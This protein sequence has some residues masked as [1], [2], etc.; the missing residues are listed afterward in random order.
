M[1]SASAGALSHL[2]L[3]F[4]TTLKQ[5]LVP[6]HSILVVLFLTL[7]GLAWGEHDRARRFALAGAAIAARL[8]LAIG[9]FGWFHRYEVYVVLFSTLVVLYVL[10]ERQR[11]LLGWYVLGLLACAGPYIEAWRTTIEGT[12]DTY[13]LQYQ[14]HRFADRFY[15]GNVA[16]NDLGLVSYGRHPDQ[17]V[18]DLIGLGSVEAASEK[19][20][21][22]AWRDGITREH[23]IGAVMIFRSW[24]PDVPPDWTRVGAICLIHPP[25]M[26][27]DSCIQFY[28]TP[29]E[30]SEDL[31]RRFSAFAKTLPPGVVPIGFGDLDQAALVK[32]Y[33]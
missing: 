33:P 32:Q 10:H 19:D 27:P 28:A 18:L 24:F 11:M 2:L 26:L 25:V 22:P 5:I 20:K 30:S 3:V 9:P 4:S 29:L 1:H 6:D 7:A 14:M 21:T 16:I 8:H 31:R 23:Q 15:T 13:L 12:R 17:Y